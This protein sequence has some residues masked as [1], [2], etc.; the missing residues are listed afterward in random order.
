MPEHLAQRLEQ[1]QHKFEKH[2]TPDQLEES[3]NQASSRHSEQIKEKQM[4]SH[5]EVEHAREVA[6]THES[7]PEDN[8]PGRILHSDEEKL[9]AAVEEKKASVNQAQRE[10]EELNERLRRAEEAEMEMKR[11]LGLA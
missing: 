6:A 9:A 2:L 1:D 8:V 4:A 3:L 10:L 5:E 11:K 7:R